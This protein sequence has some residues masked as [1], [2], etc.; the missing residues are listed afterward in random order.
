[1]RLFNSFGVLSQTF[2]SALESCILPQ[3]IADLI[4]CFPSVNIGALQS[5]PKCAS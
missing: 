2:M 3:A 1:M 5:H 4:I